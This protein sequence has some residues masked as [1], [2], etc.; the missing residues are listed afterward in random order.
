MG[1]LKVR[2]LDRYPVECLGE[3]VR[4]GCVAVVAGEH[5]RTRTAAGAEPGG[6]LPCVPGPHQ[7]KCG[8]VK[9]D[10]PS[11][12]LRFA[13]GDVP[14]LADGHEP[15]VYRDRAAFPIDVGPLEPEDFVTAHPGSR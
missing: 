14:F 13:A 9:L 2:L 7:R 4:V 15:T 5:P 1:G 10:G 6:L 8:R 3:R 11:G 12:V